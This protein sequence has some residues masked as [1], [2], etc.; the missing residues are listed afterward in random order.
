ML[1][2]NWQILPLRKD[3]HVMYQ[4]S[5]HFDQGK[6][7]FKKYRFNF[8]KKINKNGAIML[9]PDVVGHTH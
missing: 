5:Y 6:H 9:E 1:S 2:C 4:L 3:S 7:R 8:K